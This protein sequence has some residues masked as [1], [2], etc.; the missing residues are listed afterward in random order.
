MN[1]R[2]VVGPQAPDKPDTRDMTIVHRVFRREFRH[3]ADLVLQ[4]PAGDLRRAARIADHLELVIG[5]LHHH[6]RSEDE[7]L[8]PMLL[9]RATMRADL[10]HRMEHQHEHMARQLANVHTLLTTWRRSGAVSV[11][12][13]LS[14]TLR[15]LAKA[16][17]EHLDDEEQHILPLAQEC[18]TV[19]EWEK[20]GEIA[21]E[22]IPSGERFTVLGLLLEEASRAEAEKFMAMLPAIARFAWKARAR[23]GYARY[24]DRVRGDAL[25]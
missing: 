10:V 17:V 19:A 18:L 24:I 25:L 3:A 2:T 21:S 7:Y 8:W 16:L 13:E 22:K 20:L 1:A 15:L 5:L 9:E 6:H 14:A 23:R 11:A 4:A 12:G